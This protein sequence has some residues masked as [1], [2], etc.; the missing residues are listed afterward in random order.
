[1]DVK[2][3]L[4][5]PILKGEDERYLKLI[6]IL[7]KNKKCSFK[8]NAD[9][10]TVAHEYSKAL[11]TVLPSRFELL[12]L[13]ALE[14]MACGTPVIATDVGGLREIIEDGKNGFLIPPNDS[15]SLKEKITYF[16]DNPNEAEK[17]GRYARQKVLEN[18]TWDKVAERCLKIYKKLLQ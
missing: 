16:L 2:L 13:T 12:S 8:L 1:M 9:D 7:D 10:I 5:G 11:V 4:I 3:R 18:F 15:K 14:S 6:K 17:M